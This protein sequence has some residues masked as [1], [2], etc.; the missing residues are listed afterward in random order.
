M[1]FLSIPEIAVSVR[2]EQFTDR[3]CSPG[4]EVGEL[5]VT[6]VRGAASLPP[7]HMLMHSPFV[8]TNRVPGMFFRPKN[9]AD[10][11]S[12][13][14]PLGEYTDPCLTDR[15]ETSLVGLLLRG[16]T[17]VC[18]VST[19]AIGEQ[20]FVFRVESSSCFLR[21]SLRDTGNF[22]Q[23]KVTCRASELPNGFHLREGEVDG[24]AGSCDW[25]YFKKLLLSRDACVP[26]Y[27]R[28]IR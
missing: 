11:T 25:S 8:S 24:S 15:Y 22:E 2:Y 14:Q 13:V 4:L 9:S 12:E 5:Y 27:L 16:S 7:E 23:A 20:P 26:P 1:H 28:S 3:A 21:F 19:F 17:L 10:L 6:H 18:A